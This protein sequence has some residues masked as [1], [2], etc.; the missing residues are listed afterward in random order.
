MCIET[1]SQNKSGWYFF[2]SENFQINWDPSILEILQFQKWS[3]MSKVN[4]MGGSNVKIIYPYD[5]RTCVKSWSKLF[6]INSQILE[7]LKKYS[8]TRHTLWTWLIGCVN[9]IWTQLILWRIQNGHDS[10]RRLDKVEPVYLTLTSAPST[11]LKQ[12]VWKI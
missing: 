2:F 4:C 7:I 6:G 5:S 12:G 11:S 3:C 1:A 8:N 10:V 9:M